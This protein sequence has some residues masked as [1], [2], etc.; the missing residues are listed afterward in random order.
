MKHKSQTLLK[1][2]ASLIFHRT[3]LVVLLML[4]QL[5]LIGVVLVNFTSYFFYFYV[6]CVVISV[7]VVL[8]IVGNQSD[9]GY[10]I[11]W[12]IP[13]LLFPVFGGLV[14]LLFG[15]NRLSPRM[16]RKMQGMDRQ[17]IDT[18]DKDAKAER[19]KPFGM[20]AVTQSRYL[21]RY[22][23]CP[24]YTNTVTKYYPLGDD[25]FPDILEALRG[26][27]RYIFL[28]YFIVEPGLFWDSILDILEEK[29]RAGV[30]V[31]MIYDLSLIHI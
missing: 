10:K 9:P 29:A 17:M 15:G 5:G 27:Q 31:R 28:E 26:A 20:D 24:A 7:G 18:L 8:W 11:A 22:A 23:H 6:I 4:V 3:A 13:I 21:E 16:Q 1:K 19:L 2:A 14:Y 12:L 30:D 25:A